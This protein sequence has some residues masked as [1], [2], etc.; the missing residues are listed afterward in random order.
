VLAVAAACAL[1]KLPTLWFPHEEADEVI[2][3]Q[4]TDHLARTGRYSLQGTTILP[5]LDA[6]V[7]DRPLFHHPPA[8]PLLL[9][10]FVL[11]N[12]LALAVTVSWA[13][14][15]LCVVAIGLIGYDL[16]ATRDPAARSISPAL[17]IPLIG[18]AFDP[19]LTFVSRKLWIDSMLAGLTA[20]A[21]A[22]I[23]HASRS[24]HRHAYLLAGG[25]VFGLAMLAKLTAALVL[26]A[27]VFLLLTSFP[28]ARER[29]EAIALVG[30]PCLVL[31]LPWLV[32]FYRTYGVLL[33]TWSKPSA[34]LIASNPFVRAAVERPFYH[35]LLKLALLQPITIV[36][37]ALYL[38]DPKRYA[39]ALALAPLVWFTTYLAGITYLGITGSGFQTRYLAPACPAIYAM[40]AVVLL[41]GAPRHA[42]SVRLV[43]L[44]AIVLGAV[45]GLVY[46]GLPQYDEISSLVELGR[47]P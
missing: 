26:P 10:P 8:F 13:G 29:A 43:S 28:T 30:A 2:Y 22:L 38:V 5:F 14:H 7:Y 31:L 25:C 12:A 21:V 34:Q 3:W 39:N 45:Q 9:M 20:L 46:L 42:A 17:W 16:L 32:V 24:P 40:L 6:S 18:V 23:L 4:L 19:V 44:I 27:I 41:D 37:L 35:Y 36:C 1:V 15:L 33:P 47:L 11:S